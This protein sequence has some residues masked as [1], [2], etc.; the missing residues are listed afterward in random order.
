[1]T[2]FDSDIYS[3][4]VDEVPSVMARASAIPRDEQAITIVTVEEAVRGAA[5]RTRLGAPR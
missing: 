5:F 3:D 1:M 4:L 2:I